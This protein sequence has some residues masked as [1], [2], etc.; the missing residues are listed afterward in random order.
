[1]WAPLAWIANITMENHHGLWENSLQ[2]AIFNTLRWFFETLSSSDGSPLRRE[3]IENMDIP[4]YPKL[5]IAPS[6]PTWLVSKAWRRG[7]HTNGDRWVFRW[8][9]PSGFIKHGL[10]EMVEHQ[11]WL[12]G[13]TPRNGGFNRNITY[14]HCILMDHRNR[15]FS[16]EPPCIEDCPLPCR[17]TRGY[18]VA[19][20]GKNVDPLEQG[21]LTNPMIF[22]A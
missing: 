16:Y 1:M 15:W 12:A 5:Q 7:G 10:L 18:S 14:K 2:M 6:W 22:P 8:S 3:Y 9:G 4:W 19:E 13:K 20:W 17:I 21:L 11:T